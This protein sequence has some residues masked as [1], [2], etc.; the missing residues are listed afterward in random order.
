MYFVIIIKNTMYLD[1]FEK[2]F[3]KTKHVF[4]IQVRVL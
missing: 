1:R 2:Y 4:I 3:K